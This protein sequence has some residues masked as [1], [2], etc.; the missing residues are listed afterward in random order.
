MRKSFAGGAAPTSLTSGI[1]PTDLTITLDD[2]AGWED[3]GSDPFVI[4]IDRDGDTEEKIL[5]SGIS[6]TTVT[7][8]STD[9]R[10]YDGTSAQSH[11]PGAPVEHCLDADTVD[12]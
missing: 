1:S 3:L 10:G 4:I 7:V 6:G 9:D 12:E 2:D 8:D 5:C 11:D